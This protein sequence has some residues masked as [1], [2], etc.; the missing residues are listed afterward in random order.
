M[1]SVIIY[2]TFTH[3]GSHQLL[4][5]IKPMT[6]APKIYIRTEIVEGDASEALGMARPRLGETVLNTMD[7]P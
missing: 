2:A 6:G 1:K 3:S 7:L 4:H 5:K